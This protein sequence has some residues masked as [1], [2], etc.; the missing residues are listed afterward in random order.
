MNPRRHDNISEQGSARE[1]SK[2]STQVIWKDDFLNRHQ[3]KNGVGCHHVSLV[4]KKNGLSGVN[5]SMRKPEL[6]G[7]P[8]LE[9]EI[10]TGGHITNAPALSHH[11]KVNCT[12]RV[13][14]VFLR[15]YILLS[16]RTKF[17]WMY[18]WKITRV[19]WRWP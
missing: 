2:N 17:T 11:A 9:M 8:I 14:S 7:H 6:R 4:E 1:V 10:V 19:E 13:L 5:M 18:H 15:C 12:N 16:N 3:K